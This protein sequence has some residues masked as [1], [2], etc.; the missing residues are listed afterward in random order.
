MRDRFV[1]GAYD[2]FPPGGSGGSKTHVHPF[3]GDGHKH[4]ISAVPLVM[5]DGLDYHYETNISPIV[6]TSDPANSLPPYYA[7]CFIMEL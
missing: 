1:R 2:I 6:G 4:S 3:T 7:L 5:N